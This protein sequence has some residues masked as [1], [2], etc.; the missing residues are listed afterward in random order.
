MSMVLVEP[1]VY[2]QSKQKYQIT[3]VLLPIHIEELDLNP[4]LLE[5][6]PTNNGYR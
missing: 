5:S 6:A 1:R 3:Y 4:A 2:Y